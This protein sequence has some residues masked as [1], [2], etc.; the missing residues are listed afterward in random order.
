MPK[1]ATIYISDPSILSPRLFNH[2]TE[3][4]S[5]NLEPHVELFERIIIRAQWGEAVIKIRKQ[6][7][8]ELNLSGLL[9][10]VKSHSLEKGT[11]NYVQN[12]IINVRAA[13]GFT[14]H[15]TNQYEENV[16]QFLFGFNNELCGLLFLY[17]SLYDWTGE[18]LLTPNN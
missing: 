4:E 7:E 5:F 3:I 11:Q 12:R 13:L 9:S 18:E 10:Y 8:L 17:D 16:Q 15:H 14:I 6:G 2:I 1:N